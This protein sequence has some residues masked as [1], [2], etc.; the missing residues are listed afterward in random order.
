MG[1]RNPEI[2]EPS[3]AAALVGACRK[4][5]KTGRR[6]RAILLL[7]LRTGLRVSEVCNLLRA[8]VREE[9]WLEVKCGKG[10]KDRAVQLQDQ[11][12][13]DAL[14]A[15]LAV[16]PPSDYLVSTLKGARVS[17]GYVWGMTKRMARRAGVPENR[18]HP[19]I[20]RH[21]FA[22]DALRMGVP[23]PHLQHLLGHANQATTAVYLHVR[24]DEAW[25]ALAAAR[26]R[27]GTAKEN[28]KS[29]L[30]ST[31]GAA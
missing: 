7:M 28:P 3:E 23:L 14:A 1:R 10:K 25:G 27:N 15:W 9:G 17:R 6:N 19:H 22:T 5:S 11:E 31:T 29:P 4:R 2:L 26:A 16:A 12:T 8:N 21:T 24:P 13:L 20:L 18:V 30:T